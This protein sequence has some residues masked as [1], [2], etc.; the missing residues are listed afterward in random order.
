MKER[1]WT[2]GK[3]GQKSDRRD[4]RETILKLSRN[5]AKKAQFKSR[6]LDVTEPG[7]PV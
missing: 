7:K 2:D 5:A 1:D 3:Q 6:R 4:A